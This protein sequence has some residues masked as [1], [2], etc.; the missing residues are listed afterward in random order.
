MPETSAKPSITLQDVAG[1]AGLALI[2]AGAWWVYPPAAM[3]II[4]ACLLTW[5]TLASRVR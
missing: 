2:G 3:I 4:G 5:G 1:L